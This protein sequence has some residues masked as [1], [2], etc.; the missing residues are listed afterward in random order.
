MYGLV[1][2]AIEQMVRAEHGAPTWAAIKQRA[3]LDIAAF[4]SMNQYPD[5]VTYR[6]VGAASDVL[7]VPPAT[8][9]QAFGRYWMLYTS[10]EGYD[11][12]LQM[13]GNTLFEFLQNLDNMHARIGL[14][15]PHVQPPSFRCTDI[16]ERSLHVHYYSDRPGL[17]PMVTGLLEGLAIM[18]ETP[19]DI[20]LISSRE[21]GG[22]HD[23]FLIALQ[24]SG[25][26]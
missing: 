17:T 11:Q 25:N 10:K 13:T 8:I 2:K 20:T 14:I 23:V 7:G 18:F 19:I 21:T 12:L 4:V 5:D 3:E 9:L 22:D 15:Y 1:N 24:Q 6:L 26:N 16:G